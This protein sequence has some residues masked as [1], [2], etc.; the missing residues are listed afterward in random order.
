[1][2]AEK[3]LENAAIPFP[4]LA[5]FPQDKLFLHWTTQQVTTR[6]CEKALTVP[7]AAMTGV[8]LAISAAPLAAEVGA[9][10]IW[11]LGTWLLSWC[12]YSVCSN[13]LSA[14]VTG[15]SLQWPLGY[16]PGDNDKALLHH[17]TVWQTY[18]VSRCFPSLMVFT[19]YWAI[20]KMKLAICAIL[21]CSAFVTYV[22]AKG[23]AQESTKTVQF[24][25]G[26]LSAKLKR[27]SPVNSPR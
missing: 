19:S 8:T 2:R 10:H 25:I 14:P 27:W 23:L 17:W 1:M 16:H 13:E 22:N 26:T 18:V 7:Y 3:A 5:Y 24:S 11:Y 12:P 9:I 15:V 4:A 6:W 20:P 21:R